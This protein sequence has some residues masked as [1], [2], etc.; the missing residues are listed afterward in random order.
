MEITASN[1]MNN[2]SSSFLGS[3]NEVDVS[4]NVSYNSI[5][6]NPIDSIKYF[7]D[8]KLFN[9][10]K[11]NDLDEIKKVKICL[12][13]IRHFYTYFFNS[14]D[15]D[16]LTE[17][18]FKNKNQFNFMKN[19]LEFFPIKSFDDFIKSDKYSSEILTKVL[20]KVV[21][22]TIKINKGQKLLKLFPY[23]EIIEQMNTENKID[24]YFVSGVSGT[25]PTF[26]L[27]DSLMVQKSYI[28]KSS[29]SI[30]SAACRNPD[31]RILKYILSNYNDYHVGSWSTEDFV[32]TL[33]SNMFSFHIPSKYI[34]RRLKMVNEKINLS[35][36]FNHMINFVRDIDTLIIINKYYNTKKSYSIDNDNVIYKLL[37]MLD[38]SSESS[39][40][41]DNINKVFSIFGKEDDK[42]MF[43]L[44]IYLAHKKLF[45]FEV[46][47]I[48]N[49]INID[50]TIN[51][52]I[53]EVFNNDIIEIQT[54][55]NISDL[56]KI[57]NVYTPDI[58]KYCT[59]GLIT[60]PKLKKYIFMLPYIDYFP[61]NNY[62]TNKNFLNRKIMIS[63]NRLKFNIKI[64]LRKNH[65]IIQLQNKI[66]LSRCQTE[67]KQTY[68]QQQFTKLPPRN[69]LPLELNTVK[70][71]DV[72]KYLIREK[73]DGC[74]VDFISQ[75][76]FPYIKE[77]SE[78]IIKAEFIEELDLYLIFDIK[79]EN[80]TI[81]ERYDYIR[82]LHP[83][84]KESWTLNSPIE[85]FLD[86]KNSILKERENFEK[87]L[88]LPY[89]NY[90]VYPKAAWLVK[91]MEF[92]N[93]DL[94]S[95]II[96]EKDYKFIC[97]NGP[98]PNDGLIVSP[99]DGSRELKIKPKSLHTL[100]LLFNGRSWVDRENNNWSHIISNKELFPN[101][102][103]WRCYPTFK[104]NSDSEYL[105]EPK[106]YRFDKTKPNNNKV[107][108]SIY[109]LHQINWLNTL[110]GIVDG[111][112]FFYHSKDKSIS[113]SW[114]EIIHTQNKHLENVLEKIEPTIKSS[115]LDLGCGSGKL[116]NYIKKYHF[117]EYIG[118]DFDISQLLQAMKRIDGNQ[119]FQ[120][121]SRVIPTD[122]SKDWYNHSLQ[123]DKLDTSK[124]FDYIV[125]NFSLSHFHDTNFWIKLEKVSKEETFFVFNVV[126]N[127]ALTKW[128]DNNNYLYLDNDKVK[129]YF[130]QVHEKEMIEKYIPEK[131]LELI[132]DNQDWEILYK[133]TP[134]GNNLDSKYTWYVLKHQ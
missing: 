131:E 20:F 82:D 113:K 23:E 70:G 22:A 78:H 33:I 107:I 116:M 73:A 100:D 69:L 66:K 93:D 94:I 105:F 45:G 26:L 51:R 112:N 6:E 5:Q 56:S 40:I 102:T 44:N 110:N 68:K 19:L 60:E 65:K 53:D 126:N 3:G 31:N 57:F 108:M 15:I 28:D 42:A 127:N 36:Y 109:K 124:K 96:A 47:V 114:S 79:L 121:N 7:S 120:N 13:D 8:N 50:T 29:K 85:T 11:D 35:P 75:D 62:K 95:N 104:R 16:S 12:N 52:I 9:I 117:T 103:I 54:S 38:I 37:D 98:Y 92:I 123:W 14:H 86:L 97:E 76:V 130:E 125:S 77:Y 32:K 43:L 90:R 10:L 129:Y 1:E 134:K 132:L 41:I 46:P 115:W 24:L 48:R 39:D 4:E 118:L 64:W 133:I 101:D 17:Y 89:K 99:L 67:Q 71:N 84:T 34:L 83:N 122:L 88:K 18:T 63:L 49:N 87:F 106:E 91:D 111:N 2:Q 55:W 27:I 80:M 58:S 72:G 81:L 21:F 30:L 59:M 74:L 25:L 119:Y 128:I 61:V